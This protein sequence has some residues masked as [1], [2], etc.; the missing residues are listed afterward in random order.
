MNTSIRSLSALVV[1][2]VVSSA[3]AQSGG[4]F[5]GPN[6]IN[7]AGTITKTTTGQNITLTGGTGGG[8]GGTSYSF[9]NGLTLT[10]TVASS[11]LT[12]TGGLTIT[13]GS[14][15]IGNLSTNYAG[16]GLAS[17]AVSPSS[18][19]ALSTSA[20]ILY[21]TPNFASTATIGAFSLTSSTGAFNSF[22]VTSTG[23]VANLNAS[24]LSGS[25]ASAFQPAGSYLASSASNGFAPSAGS[26]SIV[27]IGT[28]STGTVPLANLGT[29]AGN[30]ILG[31]STSST[32]QAPAAYTV[33]SGLAYSSGS[34][35]ATGVQ[36]LSASTGIT[37][38]GGTTITANGNF[39]SEAV[40]TSGGL[41]LYGS[42]AS[43]PKLTFSGTG[44]ITTFSQSG[45]VLNISGST[46]TPSMVID[47]AGHVGFNS[48]TSV[49]AAMQVGT[50][51]GSS[52][53][54]QFFFNSFYNSSGVAVPVFVGNWNSNNY[55]A[56]GPASGANDGALRIGTS[57]GV[58]GKFQTTDNGFN[59]IDL[60][61][62]SIGSSANNGSITIT[63]SSGATA[64]ALSVM[65]S[66]GTQVFSISGSGTAAGGIAGAMCSA[67]GQTVVNGTA[68]SMTCSM[69]FQGSSY[70]KVAIYVNS[71]FASVGGVSYTFPTAFTQTPYVYGNDASLA[72]ASTTA[73]T[74]TLASAGSA[75]WVFVEGY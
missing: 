10:G 22:T 9:T 8:G 1:I 53:P 27:T 70:K 37:I 35:T 56:I 47:G 18:A 43:T 40:S 36:S 74:V 13:N 38:T 41:T 5:F 30:T 46:G 59:L 15:G 66:A 16:F 6:N 50:N 75:G 52:A 55:W 33:G 72:S 19:F 26:S 62:L 39:G 3:H 63:M 28:I 64:P 49:L 48:G 25:S 21:G 2:L 69:P 54:S 68:G 23:N 45:A 11:L 57:T 7:V 31:N 71:T 4:L 29:I 73:V 17:G 51:T 14:L 44:G 60:G 42:S 61:V 24:F 12:G 67:V 34:L 32:T 20:Y 58:G 65:A